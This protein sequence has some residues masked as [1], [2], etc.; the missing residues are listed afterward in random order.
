MNRSRAGPWQRSEGDSSDDE[1]GDGSSEDDG[2]DE[3]SEEEEAA[4]VAKKDRG[5]VRS[6]ASKKKKQHSH[7]LASVFGKTAAERV[8]FLEGKAATHCKCAMCLKTSK[9]VVINVPLF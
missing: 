9:V 3:G 2:D 5:K 6:F 1:A 7:T 8:K 4:P